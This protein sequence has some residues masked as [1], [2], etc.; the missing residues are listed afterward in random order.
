MSFEKEGYVMS[1]T[2]Q[3]IEIPDSVLA[4]M[5][6]SLGTAAISQAI[7]SYKIDTQKTVKEVKE[8]EPMSPALIDIVSEE[9]AVFENR[10]NLGKFQMLIWTIISITIYC[11][12]L[13]IKSRMSTLTELPDVTFTMVELMGTSQAIYLIHKI[14][15]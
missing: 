13:L 15:S 14:P 8:N 4:L 7:K 6:V 3:F 11:V 1:K 12:I 5:G 9:E 2:G 10:L